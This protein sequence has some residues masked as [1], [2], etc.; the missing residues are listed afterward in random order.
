MSSILLVLKLALSMLLL[1]FLI[2]N[3]HQGNVTVADG[4]GYGNGALKK[5]DSEDVNYVSTAEPPPEMPKVNRVK[6]RVPEVKQSE[7]RVGVAKQPSKKCDAKIAF[8]GSPLLE[9][10]RKGSRTIQWKVIESHRK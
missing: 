6:R 9:G 7:A 4:R 2:K 8:L 10:S 1:S 5:V 3:P